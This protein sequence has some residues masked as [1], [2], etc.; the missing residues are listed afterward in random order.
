MRRNKSI[1]YTEFNRLKIG[2]KIYK[3]LDYGKNSKKKIDT[4]CLSVQLI[5]WENFG[6]TEPPKPFNM[7]FEH[8]EYLKKMERSKVKFYNEKD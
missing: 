8:C 4:S 3:I 2:G 5:N 6:L 7:T 1:R